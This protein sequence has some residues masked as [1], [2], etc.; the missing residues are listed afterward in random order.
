MEKNIFTQDRR[1][2]DWL[3]SAGQDVN[4]KAVEAGHAIQ[5]GLRRRTKIRSAD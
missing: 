2:R 4:F 5:K 1:C 3:L